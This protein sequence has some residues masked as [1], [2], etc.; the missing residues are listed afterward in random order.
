MLFRKYWNL[1]E[2]PKKLQTDNRSEF[3]NRAISK[4]LEKSCISIYSTEIDS[5]SVIPERFIRTFLKKLQYH[6]FR[7]MFILFAIK[8]KLIGVHA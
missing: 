7:R 5:K 8:P 1:V 6:Q 2:K 4:Y 3:D